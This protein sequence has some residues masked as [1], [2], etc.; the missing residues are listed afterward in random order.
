[1]KSKTCTT[2]KSDVKKA[3]QLMAS[4]WT[5]VALAVKVHPCSKLISN[6]AKIKMA[7]KF[8]G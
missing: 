6:K 1:M 5:G 8:G 4:I 3:D 2:I 7:V